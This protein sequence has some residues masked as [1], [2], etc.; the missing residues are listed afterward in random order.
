MRSDP[1]SAAD[2]DIFVFSHGSLRDPL[3]LDLQNKEV[4]PSRGLPCQCLDQSAICPDSP[5]L[6]DL[7]TDRSPSGSPGCSGNRDRP[8]RIS[9]LQ[10]DD[11]KL[12][13]PVP[14]VADCKSLLDLVRDPCQPLYQ[15]HVRLVV[16]GCCA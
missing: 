8:D 5:D 14:V 9:D 2:P 10:K 16:N 6:Q 7:C 3:R 4:R 11:Q 13:T 12:Q 1:V 15:P